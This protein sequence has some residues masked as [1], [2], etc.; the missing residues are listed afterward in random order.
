M[1]EDKVTEETAMADVV[2]KPKAEQARAPNTMAGKADPVPQKR[3]E[4][5]EGPAAVV[6]VRKGVHVF[7]LVT[8]PAF[9]D[10]EGIHLT[11]IS[12]HSML[13]ILL[14]MLKVT[15]NIL[16]RLPCRVP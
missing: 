6:E 9:R 10:A 1:V 16:I 15:R 4:V 7:T 2:R 8:C 14:M 11:T 3:V 13:L 5:A 12:R